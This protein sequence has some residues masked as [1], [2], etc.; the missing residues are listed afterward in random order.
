MASDVANRLDW[1][2][3]TI[4]FTLIALHGLLD[5]ATEFAKADINP[6]FADT[7][8]GCVLDCCEEI[9]VHR[10]E[11]HGEGAIDDTAIHMDADVDFHNVILL[12]YFFAA[13]VWAVMSSNFV[14]VQAGWEAHPG[15]NRIAFGQA[16]VSDKTAHTVLDTIGDFGECLARLDGLLRPLTDLAMRLGRLTVI[17]EEIA[18]DVVKMALLFVGRTITVVTLVADLFALGVALVGKQLGDEDGWR[19]GLDRGSLLLGLLL[20]VL[21]L[22]R[23]TSRSGDS[24]FGC[25]LVRIVV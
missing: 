6:C 10:I 15:N 4:D 16:I 3:S 25:M 9:V 7:R 20:F 17:R 11:C 8:I 18:V 12:E 19:V 22:L 14:K 21:L 23:T 13:C 5:V 24:C 1:V 2:G